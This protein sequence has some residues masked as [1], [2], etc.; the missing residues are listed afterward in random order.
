MFSSKNSRKVWFCLVINF[1][2]LLFVIILVNV[3]KNPNSKYFRFGPQDDLIII[4][5]L[6]D[7]WMKW[8]I[9]ILF[10]GIIKGVDTL[11]N[12]IGSPIVGFS[13]L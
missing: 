13:C 4:S 7:N 9:A 8:I 3:F 6:I 12:E 5:I 2:V 10:I 1:A 11:V